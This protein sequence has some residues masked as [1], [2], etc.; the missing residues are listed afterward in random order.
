[1]MPTFR[2]PSK[3]AFT[4]IE[5]ILYIGILSFMVVALIQ[6]NLHSLRTGEQ[7]RMQQEIQQSGE[8]SL[9][10]ILREIRAAE[11]VN[12]EESTFDSE[13]G[14]LS[15]SIMEE[16]QNPTLISLEEGQV[17]LQQ[18]GESPIALTPDSITITQLQF[19]NLSVEGHTTTIHV[20]MEVEGELLFKSSASIREQSD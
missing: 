11:A 20:E 16:S 10:R 4:L 14:R 1:M 5:L 2:I 8:F 9:E 3:S 13:E 6:F 19:T 15:L 7:N 17:M 18:G 12:I